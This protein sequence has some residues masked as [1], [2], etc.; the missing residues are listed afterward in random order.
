MK[1]H[2]LKRNLLHTHQLIHTNLS[3]SCA[4]SALVF[5]NIIGIKSAAPGASQVINAANQSAGLTVTPD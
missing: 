1:G 5:L 3:H 2:T 4:L